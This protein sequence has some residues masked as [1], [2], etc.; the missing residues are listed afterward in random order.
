MTVTFN[1][2]DYENVQECERFW[3]KLVT[4]TNNSVHFNV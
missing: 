2:D 4:M 1:K 3:I